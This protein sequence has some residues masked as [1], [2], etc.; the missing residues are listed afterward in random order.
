MSSTP[1]ADQF[2]IDEE[3]LALRRAFIGLEE[4]D[5]Q[6]L[7]QLAPWME[8]RAGR[9]ARAFYEVQLAFAPTRELLKRLAVRRSL[10][11]EALR[12]ELEEQQSCYLVNLFGAAQGGW[13][14]EWFEGRLRE[15]VESE[16]LDVPLKWSIGGY[17]LLYRITRTALWRSMFWR[18]WLVLRAE[19]ALQ[20]VFNLDQQAITDAFLL[21]SF[22]SMHFDLASVAVERGADRTEAFGEIKRSF[23]GMTGALGD[24]ARTMATAAEQFNLISNEMN[25]RS[26]LTM[27]QSQTI[28]AAAH[29]L[30]AS[31]SEI[32]RSAT[33][34]ASIS[35]ASADGAEH[36]RVAI[37]AL[38]EASEEIGQVVKIITSIA[39]QTNLLSLN[40]SIEAARAGEAGKGFAVV[41]KEVKEL[42]SQTASSTRDITGRVGAIQSQVASIRGAVESIVET[43]RQVKE[44][45]MTIA[46][47]VEEQ[48]AA[49]REISVQISQLANMAT[50]GSEQVQRTT[51]SA[52][53][54]AERASE[55]MGLTAALTQTR[56]GGPP[57]K[58]RRSASAVAH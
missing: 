21:S 10:T 41:A 42:A 52:E 32:T 1:L 27:T 54:L 9:I 15:G 20:R 33:H 4:A 31:I 57:R 16:R 23:A 24:Q 11:F 14:L 35:A 3:T 17:P 56:T 8:E 46:G 28:A 29:Q 5:R 44:L 39:S 25:S 50:R 22:T 6:T 19:R 26:D 51:A 47:A 7:Q 58:A 43:A 12:T 40:A 13:D 48:S 37:G 38:S 53:V 34:A 45:Q 2:G 49:T 30:E 18:P 36:V 55:L